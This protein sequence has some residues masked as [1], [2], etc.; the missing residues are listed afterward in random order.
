VK[1]S[2][3]LL[4]IPKRKQLFESIGCRSTTLVSLQETRLDDRYTMVRTEW[5]W[6]FEQ[7]A[8]KPLDVTLPSTFIVQRSPD[9]LRIVFYLRHQDIMTVLR[10]RGLWNPM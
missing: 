3:L 10:E 7:S 8:E 2:D 1:A 9:G 5:R 4:A 6:R